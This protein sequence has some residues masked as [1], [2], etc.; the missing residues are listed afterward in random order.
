MNRTFKLFIAM[1]IP[2]AL[3]SC[4]SEEENQNE[5]EVQE[6]VIIEDCN[7]T[8][9][10]EA[11]SIMWTAFKTTDRVAVGGSF[12]SVLVMVPDSN[13][14]VIEAL[15]NA[16]FTVYTESVSTNNPARD[17]TIKKYFFGTLA[18]DGRLEGAIKIVEG[19][20]VE[21][22]GTVKLKINGV[23]R[24]IGFKYSVE[25]NLITIKTKNQPFIIP[26]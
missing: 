15:R 6:E 16:S 24:D 23:T 12:D 9:N 19:N 4:G 8:Y 10:A 5:Q 13:S 7:Y 3:I 11:S 17:L 26:R 1:I 25:D 18:D 14:S 2:L 22:G 20:D 21:G